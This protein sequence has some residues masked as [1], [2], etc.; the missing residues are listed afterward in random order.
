MTHRMHDVVNRK[1]IQKISITG[2]AAYRKEVLRGISPSIRRLES[3]KYY[4]YV[5]FPD[6]VVCK[7][8]KASMLLL[9][10]SYQLSKLLIRHHLKIV[11]EEHTFAHAKEVFLQSASNMSV[12]DEYVILNAQKLNPEQKKPIAAKNS[13]SKVPECTIDEIWNIIN[14]ARKKYAEDDQAKRLRKNS[15]A[16]GP[17]RAETLSNTCYS[18]IRWLLRLEASCP[19]IATI[20][21]PL[22]HD[23]FSKLDMAKQNK[24]VISS[25]ISPLRMVFA[26]KC[27]NVHPFYEFAKLESV[28]NYEIAFKKASKLPYRTIKKCVVNSQFAEISGKLDFFYKMYP[29]LNLSDQLVSTSRHEWITS[30]QCIPIIPK[31]LRTYV[32]LC[33]ELAYVRCNA[34]TMPA[35]DLV[36]TI[37][38]EPSPA[39]L[40]ILGAATEHQEDYFSENIGTAV[41]N[42]QMFYIKKILVLESKKLLRRV[43]DC[44]FSDSKELV[45]VF[46]R[47][48]PYIP[49][50]PLFVQHVPSFSAYFKEIL[51]FA[52]KTREPYYFDILKVILETYACR[53][54]LMLVQENLLYFDQPFIQFIRTFLDHL[55]VG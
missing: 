29:E 4:L 26:I 15:E 7:E 2:N 27:L 5:L 42:L 36:S 40:N 37:F 52:K 39:A 50:L 19:E 24:L 41:I 21:Q 38:P 10:S 46:L 30:P 9:L 45:E 47:E 49:S 1:L 34:N 11:L 43:V 23:I 18:L 6:I 32:K 53:S 54:D 51:S 25:K 3:L 8:Y 14:A 12:T 35:L 55:A 16:H 31:L 13:R 48:M 17:E 28:D 20:D 44:W 22:I 33:A